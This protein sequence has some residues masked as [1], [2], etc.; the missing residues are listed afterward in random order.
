M[1]LSFHIDFNGQ[2]EEAFSFYA[3]N[4][5]GK[6]GTMLRVKD[7]P[8]PA[9]SGSHGEKIVHANICVDGVELAGAD[10]ES[11]K[12]ERPKGFYVLLG[13]DS[14]EKVRSF[15]NALKTDGQVVLEPQRT[16][17]SPCYAIVVDRFGVPW[18]LNYGS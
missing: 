9:S 11:D 18:K 6:I 16:F 12:Y 17:W 4:L 3:E 14:E 13:V 1:S 10:V 5:G 7:S 2:C 8:I 15:F